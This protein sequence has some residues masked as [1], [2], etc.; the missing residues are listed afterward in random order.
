MLSISSTKCTIYYTPKLGNNKAIPIS[1]VNSYKS[2]YSRL[3]LD[4]YSLIGV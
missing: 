2:Y 3:A 1:L 4:A